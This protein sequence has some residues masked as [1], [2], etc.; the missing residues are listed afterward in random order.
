VISSF[1]TP[2]P[3]GNVQLF[4]ECGFGGRM[5]K[6]I[7]MQMDPKKMWND[8]VSSIRIVDM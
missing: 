2:P 1:P 5:A 8:N 3:S 6:T 7:S 4:E